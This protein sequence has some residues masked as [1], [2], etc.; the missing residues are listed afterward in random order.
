MEGLAQI[1]TFD[2]LEIILIVGASL[3]LIVLI[4]LLSVFNNQY[5]KMRQKRLQMICNELLEVWE[6]PLN[7]EKSKE[8][9]DERF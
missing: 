8:S 1:A 6:K 2:T 4:Y 9:K 7:H 3:L 5:T